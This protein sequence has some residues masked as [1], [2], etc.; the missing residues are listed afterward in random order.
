MHA[1]VIIFV[2]LVG[3]SSLVDREVSSYISFSAHER[4]VYVDQDGQE[5]ILN[6][7]RSESLWVVLDWSGDVEY[8]N[9]T[10]DFVERYN[11]V[12]YG[13]NGSMVVGYE[14]FIPYYPYPFV[15][16]AYETFSYR[17]DEFDFRIESAV[18]RDGMRYSV[19]VIYTENNPEGKRT[20][21]RFFV[22]AP[23]TGIVEAVLGPDTLVVGADTL[24]DRYRRLELAGFQ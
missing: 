6:V 19:E 7:V 4:Y 9:F 23:D 12:E 14:G 10:G 16:G 15:D 8:L 18:R 20:F 21:Y 2:S 22:F 5:F 11:R 13:V 3:C 17:G 1:R 24:L